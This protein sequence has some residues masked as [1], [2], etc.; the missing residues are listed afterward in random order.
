MDMRKPIVF[1]GIRIK[2]TEAGVLLEPLSGPE[3]PLLEIIERGGGQSCTR[4]IHACLVRSIQR[5]WIS[6][7]LT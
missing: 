2:L 3:S 1:A 6:E 4:R 5:D 7:T